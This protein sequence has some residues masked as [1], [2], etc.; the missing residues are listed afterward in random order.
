MSGGVCAADLRTRCRSPAGA[1]RLARQA[2]PASTRYPPECGRDAARV[3]RS[4]T[5]GSGLVHRSHRRGKKRRDR[6]RLALR[7]VGSA[8]LIAIAAALSVGIV[9]VVERPVPPIRGMA[10]LPPSPPVPPS[11]PGVA[12]DA[13]PASE[14]GEADGS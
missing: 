12:G 1:P 3:E 13:P 5:R 6:A 14:P 11:M 8:L 10:G 2:A 7:V 4:V 9:H